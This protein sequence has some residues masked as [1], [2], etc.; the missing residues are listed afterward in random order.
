MTILHSIIATELCLRLEP[1]SAPRQRLHQ[2]VAA[3]PQLTTPGAKWEL[4][5]DLVGTLNQNLDLAERGCWDF[6]DD[7][8]RAQRD[9]KMWS[10]GMITKEGVREGPSQRD[11]YR[12][13]EPLYMTF[14]I[15][16]LLRQGSPG[17]RTLAQRCDIPEGSLW[18]RG[19]F[20]H[21]LQSLTAVSFAS[22]RA[23]VVYLIP[24]DESWGL[25]AADLALPKFH[26]LRPIV[27]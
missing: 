19:T 10:D 27:G 3:H 1:Q 25:T 21:I 6:F 4:V 8:A 7:D 20:R 26:Y 9:F 11:A 14:T 24:G 18:A 5:R 12:G 16:L 23:D 13:G 22:V 15:A 17:E 2:L